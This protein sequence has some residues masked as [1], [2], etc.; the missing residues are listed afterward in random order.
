MLNSS[1]SR[2]T[3][4]D[5]ESMRWLYERARKATCDPETFAVENNIPFTLLPPSAGDL[6]TIVTFTEGKRRSF[7]GQYLN[8]MYDPL[9]GGRLPKIRDDIEKMRNR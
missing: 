4:E 5:E 2:S 1:L 3:Q 8:R 7:C 6:A 9:R